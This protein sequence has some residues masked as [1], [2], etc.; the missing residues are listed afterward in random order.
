MAANTGLI[1]LHS[2][3]VILG[4]FLTAVNLQ[5]EKTKR[6]WYGAITLIFGN[7]LLIPIGGVEGSAISVILS[8]GLL[9]VLF[10]I[11]LV[12]LLGWPKMGHTFVMCGTA[13]FSFMIPFFVLPP[14][15]LIFKVPVSVILYCACLFLFKEV[16]RSEIPKLQE[17]YLNRPNRN[18][19]KGK[20]D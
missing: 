9:I 4:A 14:S 16:R 19:S 15:P 12:S 3:R 11:P 13:C 2:V 6:E 7:L 17:L 8:E 1:F 18:L 20:E 5:T 10:M